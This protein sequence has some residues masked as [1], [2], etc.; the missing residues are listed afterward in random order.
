[1]NDADGKNDATG[2]NDAGGRN[3]EDDRNDA[4]GKNDTNAVGESNGAEGKMGQMRKWYENGIET[5][6]RARGA[7]VYEIAQ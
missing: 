6:I 1:M 7:Y 3:D 4:D 5:Q 2:E